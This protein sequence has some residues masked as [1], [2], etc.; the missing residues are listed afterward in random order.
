VTVTVRPRKPELW[1]RFAEENAYQYIK[2]DL[3]DRSPEAFW[4]SGERTVCEEMVPLL[5]EFNIS[6]RCGL[7]IGCGVGRL[8]LPLSQ[9]FHRMIGIDI[10]D[11]MVRRAKEA[12]CQRQISNAEFVAVGEPAPLPAALPQDVGEISFIYSLLVFQHIPDFG[13]IESYIAGIGQMLSHDGAAYLQFDTRAQTMPYHF[14]TALPDLVL[15]KYWRRGIRRIRRD[16]AEIESTFARQ[17]LKIVQEWM[18]RTAD[19]RYLLRAS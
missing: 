9:V 3:A 11:G 19:H 17:G 18:P 14:K 5:Q 8:V 1:E 2:T 15:P 16:P 7:E 4:Q 13:T 10:S 6:R 12:A